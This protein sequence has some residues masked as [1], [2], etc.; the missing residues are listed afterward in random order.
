MA[1]RIYNICEHACPS[2]EITPLFG[3]D[4]RRA[5]FVVGCD[6]DPDEVCRACR[7]KVLYPEELGIKRL[8]KM[9]GLGE[10]IKELI[11]HLRGKNGE[12]EWNISCNGLKSPKCPREK[13]KVSYKGEELG[14][15]HEREEVIDQDVQW[16]D[17]LIRVRMV[18]LP[19]DED[20]MFGC[21]ITPQDV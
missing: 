1:E 7:L 3:V 13:L 14:M 5:A 9:N 12:G 15:K 4:E 2:R 18:V 6:P 8:V 10:G 19:P 16:G 11:K 17:E 20:S 21:E